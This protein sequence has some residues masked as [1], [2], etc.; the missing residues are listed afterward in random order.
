MHNETLPYT[1]PEVP[2]TRMSLQEVDLPDALSPHVH[3]SHKEVQECQQGLL[4]PQQINKCDNT[5]KMQ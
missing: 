3:A 4:G 5:V 2:R 1:L